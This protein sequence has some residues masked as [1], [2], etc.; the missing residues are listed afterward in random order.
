MTRAVRASVPAPAPRP[1]PV[2]VVP[3]P[4]PEAWSIALDLAGGD[5]RRLAVSP[6]GRLVTVLNRPR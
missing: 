1:A 5:A 6:G 3:K 2:E 4:D